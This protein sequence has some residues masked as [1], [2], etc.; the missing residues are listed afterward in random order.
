M[1]SLYLTVEGQTEEAFAREL[2]QPQLSA[3]NVFLWPPRFTGPH[4]RRHG[5]IPRGGMFHTFQHTLADMRRWL[6]E[7]QSPDA[8]FSMMVDLYHLPHDFPGYANGMAQ[9]DCYR[10]ADL[11]E[12][13]IG[14]E[15]G[16]PRFIPYLQVHEFEALALSEPSHFADWFEGRLR[17]LAALAAECQPYDTPE[18]IDHGQHSHPKAR[19][20]KHFEDYDEDLH[21][22]L[23]TYTIGLPRLRERCPH[24]NHWLTRLEQLDQGGP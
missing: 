8:R 9:A 3:F 7:N 24:F 11:L 15:L 18:R 22:P 12:A 19:I 21:G 13:A 4:G 20:K 14:E 5:R 10:Q 23:I 6:K 1:K 17:A 16:D 2:L